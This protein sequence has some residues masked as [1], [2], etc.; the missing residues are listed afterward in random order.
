LPQSIVD[1]T[2]EG[3]TS[4][5]CMLPFVERAQNLRDLLP[6]KECLILW[7]QSDFG[8]FLTQYSRGSSSTVR[9]SDVL[10][11]AAFCKEEVPRRT[12]RR[13]AMAASAKF[14]SGWMSFGLF[15][16]PMEVLGYVLAVMAGTVLGPF[17]RLAWALKSKDG[18]VLPSRVSRLG[19]KSVDKVSLWH[20]EG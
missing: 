1:Y 2:I 6:D 18:E 10:L 12:L 17:L 20:A 5:D 4:K 9:W 16:V 8:Q 7:K 19:L 14:K 11:A 15:P 13:A 3:D